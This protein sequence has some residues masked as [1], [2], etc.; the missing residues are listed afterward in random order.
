[1][2]VFDARIVRKNESKN[3]LFLTIEITG[4]DYYG[5]VSE[6]RPGDLF[7]FGCTELDANTGEMKEQLSGA[8]AP[9]TSS[10]AAAPQSGGSVTAAPSPKERNHWRGNWADIPLSQQAGIRC[11]DSEFKSFLRYHF[12]DTF[13]EACGDCAAAVRNLCDVKSRAEFDVIPKAAGRWRNLDATFQSW[14][15]GKAHADTYR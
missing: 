12:P 11:G 14:L 10:P 13:K 2:T 4:E 9:P 7:R 15:T 6:F 1:M 3:G 5:S 8:D